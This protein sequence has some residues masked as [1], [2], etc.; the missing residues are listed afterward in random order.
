M[1]RPNVIFATVV[2]TI[3]IILGAM[4]AHF[5]EKKLSSDLI[6]TFEKGVKYLMYSGLGLLILSL[7]HDR[8]LF[9]MK[10]I[11]FLIKLGTVLFSLNIFIYVFHKFVPIFEHFVHLVP[12]GGFLMILGWGLLVFQL[13]KSK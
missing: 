5:L 6:E 3:S 7:N 2:I 8:F 1:S 12:I 10:T 13:I 4:A 11:Y 9:K